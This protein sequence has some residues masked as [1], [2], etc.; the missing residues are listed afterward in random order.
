MSMTA[1]IDL[2]GSFLCTCFAKKL[3]LGC[4]C[5]SSP[6]CEPQRKNAFKLNM[7]ML[8]SCLIE[9]I[10]P[11]WV[12]LSFS[13][14]FVLG[15]LR[16]FA[17]CRCAEPKTCLTWLRNLLR[18]FCRWTCVCAFEEIMMTHWHTHIARQCQCCSFSCL[19]P[20]ITGLL[21]CLLFVE[22][23]LCS[24]WNLAV[25]E[26]FTKLK[27]TKQHD[28]ESWFDRSNFSWNAQIWFFF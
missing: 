21:G 7:S 28:R 27:A 19:F 6:S 22:L 25:A 1:A 3:A 15:T 26:R 9:S 23:L 4:C 8:L 24:N 5:S 14:L 13:T 20:D 17:F 16:G 12:C 18:E 11:P 10:F 2:L